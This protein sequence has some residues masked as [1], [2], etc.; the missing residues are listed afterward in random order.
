MTFSTLRLK[1]KVVGQ[2]SRSEEEKCFFFSCEWTLLGDVYI[3]NRQRSALNVHVTKVI[4]AISSEAF[5]VS[6]C[7]SE[8][9]H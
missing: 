4:G 6:F 2:R 8:I 5:L 7:G 9:Q 1:V 3:L